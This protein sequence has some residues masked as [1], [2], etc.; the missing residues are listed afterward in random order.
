LRR[1]LDG[2]FGSEQR[3]NGWLPLAKPNQNRWCD[4]GNAP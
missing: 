1:G 2:A 3:C 4:H